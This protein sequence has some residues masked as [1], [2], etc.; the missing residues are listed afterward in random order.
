VVVDDR[1]SNDASLA[2]CRKFQRVRRLELGHPLEDLYRQR[3]RD[4]ARARYRNRS[5]ATAGNDRSFVGHS[6]HRCVARRQLNSSILDLV[7][8]RVEG[9]NARRR[10]R[11]ELYA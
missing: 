7:A 6:C 1:V 8:E 3:I 4:L 10:T 2:N 5:A 11:G 9:V